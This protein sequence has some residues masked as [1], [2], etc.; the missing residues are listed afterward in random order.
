MH[1]KAPY[2]KSYPE[3]LFAA[4]T[5][6]GIAL[7]DQGLATYLYVVYCLPP[8]V[9]LGFKDC[10]PA[11]KIA[12]L[13]KS[14]SPQKIPLSLRS[15]ITKTIV[16]RDEEFLT[17][18]WLG[19]PWPIMAME[20]PVKE[21]FCQPGDFINS[22]RERFINRETVRNWVKTP[23]SRS[24]KPS[25]T[26]VMKWIYAHQKLIQGTTVHA[27][28]KKTWGEYAIR[29]LKDREFAK[30]EAK[31]RNQTLKENEKNI[32]EPLSRIELNDILVTS[33]MME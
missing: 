26:T 7:P 33:R 1:V 32:C 19:L 30:S 22:V 21:I 11:V 25:A 5:G 27:L 4:V 23:V 18:C 8:Q 9:Y 24:S 12:N 2:A 10:I 17:Q 6:P 15:T 13:E 14:L 16:L 28:D 29:L 20:S 31:T 3:I